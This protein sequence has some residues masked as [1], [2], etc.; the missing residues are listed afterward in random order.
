MLLLISFFSTVVAVPLSDYFHSSVCGNS[1]VYNTVNTTKQCALDCLPFR[2][3]CSRLRTSTSYDF[4]D[5]LVYPYF[6]SRCVTVT[7]AQC[8]YKPG[9][10]KYIE[11]V[12]HHDFHNISMTLCFGIL[13]TVQADR[14]Y[15]RISYAY[16][17]RFVSDMSLLVTSECSDRLKILPPRAS[18]YYQFDPVFVCA[19][20]DRYASVLPRTL[21]DQ[22]ISAYRYPTD[23][24]TLDTH[25]IY[26][27]VL[28]AYHPAMVSMWES[29]KRSFPLPF[30]IFSKQFPYYCGRFNDSQVRT[31]DLI[32]NTFPETQCRN[33]LTLQTYAYCLDWWY[34]LS[35]FCPSELAPQNIVPAPNYSMFTRYHLMHSVPNATQSQVK[36]DVC[37][38]S[39]MDAVKYFIDHHYN[40][41]YHIFGHVPRGKRWSFTGML[42]NA[43]MSVF[44]ELVDLVEKMVHRLIEPVLKQL[45]KVLAALMNEIV[46]VVISFFR[47][48][49][50]TLIEAVDTDTV[51]QSI[52]GFL[53]FLWHQF[54]TFVHII[55]EILISSNDTYRVLEYFLISVLLT[56]Y[57]KLYLLSV[58]LII[59]LMYFFPLHREAAMHEEFLFCVLIVLLMYFLILNRNVY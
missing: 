47:I 52:V 4:T 9:C 36:E 16:E 37:E 27:E 26:T 49:L 51:G 56:N 48:M 5:A 46:P 31:V 3:E 54:T 43:L 12:F 11:R 17:D 15:T 1:L 44:S 30:Q 8:S 35:A 14:L 19:S 10:T 40:I 38:D 32:I 7:T 42:Q 20:G 53:V 50:V 45:I 55:L 29:S 41:T 39:I 6:L 21:L 24:I 2:L 18:W 59:T 22:M 57:T 13:T 28:I 25:W 58:I 33:T 34:S 23:I